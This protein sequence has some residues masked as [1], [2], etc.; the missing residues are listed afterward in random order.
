MIRW[1]PKKERH[2][3]GLCPEGEVWI[4]LDQEGRVLSAYLL[5]EGREKEKWLPRL[6]K[7]EKLSF[8]KAWLEDQLLLL[9][10][11]RELAKNK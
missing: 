5:L 1:E 7:E 2:V 4:R 8:A 6:K 3:R 10:W 11:E 9:K